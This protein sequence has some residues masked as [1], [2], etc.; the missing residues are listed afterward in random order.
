MKAIDRSIRGDYR[1]LNEDVTG[2]FENGTGQMLMLVADGM[3]GHR[4]GDVASQFVHDEIKAAWQEQNLLNVEEGVEFLRRLVMDVNRRMYDY[5]QEHPEYQG[6]GTTLVLCAVIEETLIIL[7]VGDSRAYVMN[8]RG[9]DQV[10]NDHSFV[11]LLVDAG[12]ITAE[13]AKRHPKRN[14]ITKAMGTDRLIQADV[15]RL[16]N[17]QYDYL[18]LASD[19]LTDN[20][21]DSELHAIIRAEAAMTDKAAQLTER[22]IKEG[23]T[24]NISLVLAD[25]K[26]SGSV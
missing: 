12:E 3:G 2:I 25:L 19:G 1:D 15:F 6:M 22:A 17:R 11:N 4:Y 21:D 14:I 13:E 9:I 5:Q 10:T 23:S 16:R 8:S 20:L 7:N 24:D 26:A 18:L